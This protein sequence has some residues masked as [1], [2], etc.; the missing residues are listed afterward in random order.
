MKA[1]SG[2]KHANG[3]PSLTIDGKRSIIAMALK[4]RGEKEL[5]L[6]L[7][8]YEISTLRQLNENVRRYKTKF[9]EALYDFAHINL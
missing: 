5:L 7:K 3:M 8:P 9:F 4:A 1:R 6:W 2:S